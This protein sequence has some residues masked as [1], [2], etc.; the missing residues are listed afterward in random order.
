MIM[1]KDILC[2]QYFVLLFQDT[3]FKLMHL[4]ETAREEYRNAGEKGRTTLLG[5]HHQ[6]QTLNPSSPQDTLHKEE[7]KK[8]NVEATTL[9]RPDYQTILLSALLNTPYMKDGEASPP[10]SK[11]EED[12]VV[13]NTSG[14]SSIHLLCTTQEG[15]SAP[16]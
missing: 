7:K 16:R 10:D 1:I 6:P 5:K 13:E 14:S 11:E 9:P 4:V 12:K 2:I 15:S 3:Y 8:P